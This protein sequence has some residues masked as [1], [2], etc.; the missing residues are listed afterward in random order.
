MSEPRYEE[1]A[2][3]GAKSDEPVAGAGGLVHYQPG[4]ARLAVSAGRGVLTPDITLA[5]R[6]W[7]L[8][9]RGVPL[10]GLL[11]EALRGGLAPL[12]DLILFELDG[13]A[14]RV[15]VRGALDVRVQVAGGGIGGCSGHLVRT[16]NEQV[17]EHPI[18]ATAGEAT[19][20]GLPLDSGIVLASGFRW[21]APGTTV[22]DQP[23]Q[24][25]EIKTAIA[26]AVVTTSKPAGR[27]ELPDTRIEPIDD[28]F[29]HLFESTVMRSIEDAAVRAPDEEVLIIG[30]PP[31]Q[32]APD[33]P[34]DHDGRTVMAGELAVLL[35]S[36]GDPVPASTG[37]PALA[38]TGTQVRPPILQLS[39]G[40]RVEMDRSVVIGRRPQVDR[41]SGIDIPHLVTVP[42]PQQDISRSHL[43]IRP[44]AMGWVAVDLGSTNGSVIRRAGGESAVLANGALLDLQPGDTIDLGDGVTA[45]LLAPS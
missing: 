1:R 17:F 11:E 26:S 43:A 22:V 4:S 21:A 23:S 2:H 10:S 45:V 31:A 19:D 27:S 34:G 32:V 14:L 9:A 30:V 36:T 15:V 33:R 20:T 6:L 13:H 44:G 3:D 12:P 35:A 40:Q 41:V 39:T 8:I 29:Q 28:S 24:D 38:S 18:L 25:G 7:P 37:D 5:A 42:S 16:W